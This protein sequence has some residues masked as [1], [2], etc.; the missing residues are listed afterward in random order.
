MQRTQTR[1]RIS[2]GLVAIVAVLALVAF[3][4][5]VSSGSSTTSVFATGALATPNPA[6]TKINICIDAKVIGGPGWTKAQIGD[7][8]DGSD[9]IWGQATINITWNNI[10]TIVADPTAST[11]SAIG[12]ILS[13]DNDVEAGLLDTANPNTT[14]KDKCVRVYFIG[15]FVDGAGNKDTNTLAV[16]FDRGPGAFILMSIQE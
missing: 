4:A 13:D 15:H 12:D 6:H 8:V 14:G 16:T 7:L 9:T 5:M 2:F 11:G 3:M 10:L 1:L